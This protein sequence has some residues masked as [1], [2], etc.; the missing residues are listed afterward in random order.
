[1]DFP[2]GEPVTRQRGVAVTDPYSNAATD[3]DWTTPTTVTYP[4][5]AVWQETSTEPTQD[6]RAAV[7]TVT[8]AALPFEADVTPQD[9]FVTRGKTYEVLGEPEVVHSPFTGWEPGVVVTGRLVAG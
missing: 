9:R 4:L 5:C 2:H 8:K 3:I 7:I 1:M 6:G